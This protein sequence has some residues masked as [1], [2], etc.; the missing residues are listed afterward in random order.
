MAGPEAL[1]RLANARG[2]ESL[3]LRT[4]R[5]KLGLVV[6]SAA[7][8]ADSGLTGPRVRT[9]DRNDV[10]LAVVLPTRGSISILYGL[11]TVR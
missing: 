5:G 2:A 7:A 9:V 11:W 4:R 1:C 6:F 8:A 3:L 10:V